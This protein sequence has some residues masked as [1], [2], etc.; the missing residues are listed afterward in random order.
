MK[1][2]NILNLNQ[3]INFMRFLRDRSGKMYRFYRKVFF[4]SYRE[5]NQQ[6][7]FVKERE[8]LIE[9]LV[10]HPTLISRP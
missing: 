6:L 1:E 2:T 10:F 8:N 5:M 4:A 3:N 7:E 9:P